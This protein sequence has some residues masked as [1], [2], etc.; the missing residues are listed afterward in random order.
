MLGGSAGEERP[1]RKGGHTLSR[2]A[3]KQQAATAARGGGWEGRRVSRTEYAGTP[4]ADSF[5]A[6]S[7]SFLHGK[8]PN[9]IGTV[10]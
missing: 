9:A 2:R 8:Y 1:G 6:V 5:A 3:L 7:R 10:V 4:D